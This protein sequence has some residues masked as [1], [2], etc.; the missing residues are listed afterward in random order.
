MRLKAAGYTIYSKYGTTIKQVLTN[1]IRLASLSA[2]LDSPPLG[3]LRNRTGHGWTEPEHSDYRLA[4]VREN[5]V[6]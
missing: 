6:I 4:C 5:Q 2:R 1:H 3:E